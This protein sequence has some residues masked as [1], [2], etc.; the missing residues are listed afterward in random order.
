VNLPPSAAE[1][2]ALRQ[3]RL[4]ELRVQQQNR[5]VASTNRAQFVA[6]NRGRPQTVVM[7]KP[8]PV[9]RRQPV[10]LGTVQQRPL[11]RPVNQP[12]VHPPQGMRPQP[13]A[14]VAQQVPQP[15]PPVQAPPQ[16]MRPAQ[17]ERP[18]QQVRPPAPQERPA[19][20]LH[21]APQPRPAPPARPVQQI[22][23]P[24]PAP[25]EQRPMPQAR[26][27]PPRPQEQ[28][29]QAPRPEQHPEQRPEQHPE[30]R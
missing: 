1:L 13:P 17:P 14:R 7:A 30:P 21:P 20:Q 28:R 27:E 15:R 29:Q 12:E 8:L 24:R 25:T 18:V 5:V 22:Q 10:Q 4:P 26:P 19:P 3:P 16:P 6:E 23:Q 11:P 2:A 9:E